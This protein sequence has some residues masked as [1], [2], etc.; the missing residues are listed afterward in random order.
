MPPRV[1]GSV[2]T[3]R[4]P[5]SVKDGTSIRYRSAPSG[6]QCTTNDPNWLDRMNQVRM[7][8]SAADSKVVPAPQN[9]KESPA[10]LNRKFARGQRS[11]A[12]FVIA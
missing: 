10:Q 3:T 2:D 6:P 1:P 8:I 5:M 7:A 4:N 11:A 12:C 9:L